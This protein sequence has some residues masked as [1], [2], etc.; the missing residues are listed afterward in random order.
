M[1][2]VLA[3]GIALAICSYWL[4]TIELLDLATSALFVGVCL[5]SV[6]LTLIIYVLWP[7]WRS[8]GIGS[9]FGLGVGSAIIGIGVWAFSQFF[10]LPS[11]EFQMPL[12]TSVIWFLWTFCT[13]IPFLVVLVPPILKACFIAFPSLKPDLEE[14]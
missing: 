2:S 8:Y 13:E 4:Y 14:E 5:F 10:M 3:I 7:K 1:I 9:I 6:I 11:G 12:Y